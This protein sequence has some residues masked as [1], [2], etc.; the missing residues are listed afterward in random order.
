MVVAPLLAALVLVL[1]SGVIDVTVHAMRTERFLAAV[2]TGRAPG[3]ALVPRGQAC[4]ADELVPLA[5]LRDGQEPLAIVR[6]DEG[7]PYR[8]RPDALALVPPF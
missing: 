2:R 7:A 5:P 6:T 3:L 1:V 4:V 8:A